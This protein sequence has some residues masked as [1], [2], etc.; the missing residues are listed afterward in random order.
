MRAAH[1]PLYIG[2]ML[3][4]FSGLSNAG[5]IARQ[6]ASLPDIPAPSGGE[7]AWIARA[8]RLNG[9][10]MT[11]KSFVSPTNADEVLHEYERRLRTSSDMQTR[12]SRD[13]AWQ[14]L[15]VMTNNYFVTIRARDTVRGTEGTITVTPALENARA[16]KYTRFPHPD[17]AQIVSVQEYEDDGIE[18]EHISFVSRRSAAIEARD[19]ATNLEQ[20]G[21]HLLRNEPSASGRNAHVVEAQKAAALAFIHLRRAETGGTTTILVVWRKA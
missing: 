10:P 5:T 2:L 13:G 14:V 17:S 19:F 18:A 20:Q 9:V 8:M 15:A 3:I 1:A 6:T 7:G 21:W 16:R 11:I 12:R 4:V